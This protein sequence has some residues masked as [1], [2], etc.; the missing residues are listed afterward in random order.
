MK[1]GHVGMIPDNPSENF[2]AKKRLLGR[3][4]GRLNIGVNSPVKLMDRETG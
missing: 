3:A 4:L 1:H 2:T